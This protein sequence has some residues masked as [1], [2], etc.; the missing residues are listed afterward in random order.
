MVKLVCILCVSN[1]FLEQMEQFLERSRTRQKR[2]RQT[3]RA[4]LLALWQL[5]AD[6][7]TVHIWR[8]R[9]FELI[10]FGAH[11]IL[12]SLAFTSK[13]IFLY[14]YTS[15]YGGFRAVRCIRLDFVADF[16]V[17]RC[18]SVSAFQPLNFRT[19]RNCLTDALSSGCQRKVV[20]FHACSG[21][22]HLFPGQLPVY[23]TLPWSKLSFH[24]V[25]QKINKALIDGRVA[26]HLGAAVGKKTL[27][28]HVCV[29]PHFGM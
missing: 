22:V 25:P 4:M 5:Y 3:Q 18:V 29:C 23:S 20:S 21:A 24:C 9:V 17:D 6:L 15:K 11:K 12:W 8:T 1:C 10:F 16:A 7:Q 13:R 27:S 28:I 14:V 26:G 2:T 19:S